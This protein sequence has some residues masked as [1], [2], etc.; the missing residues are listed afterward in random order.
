MTNATSITSTAGA[1]TIDALSGTDT[2]GTI[3]SL[4]ISTLPTAS[5]GTLYLADGVTAV[6]VG[7]VLTPAQASSLKFDPSGT[8]T[9]NST[10]TFTVTDNLGATDAT[11]AT[12][13]IAITG[14]LTAQND[15]GNV[16]ESDTLSVSAANGVILSGTASGG[17]DT[18]SSGYALTLTAIRTGAESGSGTAGTID[19]ALAGTYGHLTLHA[20]GSYGYVADTAAAIALTNGVTATDTF[21]YTVSDGHGGTDTAELAITVTGKDSTPIDLVATSQILT[22]T[23]LRGEYFG[24]ND[25]NSYS[26]GA[27][28][29]SHADDNTFTD[30]DT[31]SNH[32]INSIAIAIGIVNDRNGSTIFGTAQASADTAVDAKW[33][34]TTYNYDVGSSVGFKGGYL[35]DLGNNP[36]GLGANAAISSGNLST[37]LSSDISSL[38]T[39][40]D[41]TTNPFGHTTDAVYRTTGAIY[42]A[43]G[44]YDMRVVEDDG[45]RILVDGKDIGE[46][47]KNDNATTY[48]YRNIT[49]TTGFHTIETIGW[50]QGGVAKSKIEFKLS[51][52]PDSAYMVLSNQNFLVVDP[53]SI[54]ALTWQDTIVQ[55]GSTFTQW[56]G[57][58]GN[59]TASNETING[60]LYND[61]INGGAGNDTINAAEGDDRVNE[62]GNL[63][64]GA[65]II[66]LGMGNDTLYAG[67]ETVVGNDSY[68]GGAGNDTLDYSAATHDITIYDVVGGSSLTGMF[69]DPINGGAS[70]V[71]IGSD[72]GTDTF[73]SFETFL[74]GS[75]N[76]VINFT[77]LL[78]SIS[79]SGGAGNDTIHGGSGNDTISGGSGADNLDGGG[80]V[81]TLSYATSLTAVTVDLS[82]NSASGGDAQGDVISHFQNLIGGA[83]NDVLTALATG[84]TIIGGAGN[85]TITGGAGNDIVNEQGTN[86]AGSD[87]VTLGDGNDTLYAGGEISNPSTI[88]SN[89]TNTWGGSPTTADLVP[90][91]GTYD[92][93]NAYSGGNGTD[94]LDFSAATHDITVY[95]NSGSVGLGS[96][97]SG[98][99]V[100]SD[101]GN[102][103]VS[104]FEIYVFGSGNDF[105]RIRGGGNP[106]SISGGGGNDWLTSSAQ[107]DF[108]DGGSGRDL[109]WAKEGDDTIVFDL[110]DQGVDGGQGVDTFLVQESI[111]FNKLK[112]IVTNMNG[113]DLHG[114]SP[115]TISGLSLDTIFNMSDDGATGST[116]NHLFTI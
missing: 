90:Y 114:T 104:G 31:S 18:S 56:T 43:D 83:G 81:N 68:N 39:G 116:T 16:N 111:N 21:T 77:G 87:T 72:I 2:D 63:G 106:V 62:M 13:T 99:I 41:Q 69:E 37:F 60:T 49:L 102:V 35:S 80:G 11:P 54:A 8:Y 86:G 51:S 48:I 47:D 82:T 22:S 79:V 53:S 34:V 42:V 115:I 71:A 109:L 93:T 17:T 96:D 74:L 32:N 12:A 84:S 89:N 36:T 50:D 57:A 75:G 3:S 6:T 14:A 19:T 26:A 58:T 101:I 30:I 103:S 88:Y 55:S 59:G 76:D 23:G 1:T 67:N 5:Q 33:N 112:A 97:M 44:T 29:V 65:D 15:T 95:D 25:N 45:F 4:T 105:A 108:L 113:L 24:Y 40:T 70:G 107:N 73:T 94:T 7:Q 66:N 98:H 52:E 9:G 64:S 110:S 85:D 38:T 10:F 91:S 28:L 78:A 20:D 92:A 100:G 61:A 46:I 27:S